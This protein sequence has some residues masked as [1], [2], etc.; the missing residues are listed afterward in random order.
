MIAAAVGGD[1]G[2]CSC[3]AAGAEHL[4]VARLAEHLD[5]WVGLGFGIPGRDDDGDPC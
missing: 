2:G 5:G 1:G 4:E 3:F